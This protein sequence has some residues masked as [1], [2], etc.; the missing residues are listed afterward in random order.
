M[1]CSS[2]LLLSRNSLWSAARSVRCCDKA[3][4]LSRV[5]SFASAK[6]PSA[7]AVS[8]ITWTNTYTHAG[9]RRG[10]SLHPTV[11]YGKHWDAC[12][13]KKRAPNS[14]NKQDHQLDNMHPMRDSPTFVCGM[15]GIRKEEGGIQGGE[16]AFGEDWGAQRPGVLGCTVL[17]TLSHSYRLCLCCMLHW[18]CTCQPPG[19]ANIHFPS[20]YN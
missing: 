8:A 18:R 14:K 16:R 9:G 3:A 15:G 4:L 13:S 12:P 19:D 5:P 10:S 6:T 1:A 2:R 17:L 11:G 7:D 20:T